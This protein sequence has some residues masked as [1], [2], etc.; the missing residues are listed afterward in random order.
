MRRNSHHHFATMTQVQ[1][2]KMARDP[3]TPSDVLWDIVI[4]YNWRDLKDPAMRREMGQAFDAII[5]NPNSSHDAIEEAIPTASNA[6]LVFDNHAF[7]LWAIEDPSLDW[8][9]DAYCVAAMRA[10]MIVGHDVFD[11]YRL[12]EM[13]DLAWVQRE[14]DP[15]S[16]ADAFAEIAKAKPSFKIHPMQFHYLSQWCGHGTDALATLRKHVASNKWAIERRS[17]R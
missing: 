11:V 7:P 15:E 5:S 4:F 14:V 3:R 6:N 9:R 16:V 12:Q 1:R 2:V 17:G 13:Y 10:A 8:L